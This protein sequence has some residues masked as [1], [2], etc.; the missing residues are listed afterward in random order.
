MRK[1]DQNV[2]RFG[3]FSSCQ[4]SYLYLDK[5]PIFF[6]PLLFIQCVTSIQMIYK[7]IMGQK[8][9]KSSMNKIVACNKSK[10]YFSLL[11]DFYQ[12]TEALT[13]SFLHR[14]KFI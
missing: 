13:Y 1:L 14:N 8:S 6:L 11:L 5:S 10:K 7:P 3:N 4:L 9:K 2:I 12:P